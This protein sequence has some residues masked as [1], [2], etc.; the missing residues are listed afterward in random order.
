MR[1]TVASS[2]CMLRSHRG[3]LGGHLLEVGVG[4]LVE[5]DPRA[6]AAQIAHLDRVDVLGQP[7][8]HG[9]R[10]PAC[11]PAHLVGAL[12]SNDRPKGAGCDMR[13]LYIQCT[14]ASGFQWNPRKATAN[15][16]KHGVSFEDAQSVFTDERARLIDDPDHS[17]DEERYLLL[18]IGSSLRLLVVA[19]CYR[20]AGSVIR[21]ISARKATRE[22]Q[23]FYP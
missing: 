14:H 1:R 13:T 18:G 17:S 20:E 15:L 9:H 21:I 10:V 6:V 7:G 2:S 19:H 4:N 11:R 3:N 5:H 23:S 8:L 16:R 22:E 12:S